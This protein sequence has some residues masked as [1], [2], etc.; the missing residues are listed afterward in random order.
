MKPHVQSSLSRL[1]KWLQVWAL[2]DLLLFVGLGNGVLEAQEW[3]TYTTIDGLANND[4][5]SVYQSRDGAMW[6]GTRGGVSRFDGTWQTFTIAEGL[7]NNVVWSVFESRDGAMWFG[8]E[9]GGVSRYD[10]KNWQTFTAEDGL[11]D[12]NIWAVF[13]ARDGAMWFGARDYETQGGGGG[14]SRYDGEN[15][16]S[17]T[18]ADGLL[19]N[20]VWSIFEARDGA[21][22]FGTVHVQGAEGGGVSRY[23]GESWQ[24]Y[25]TK[26]GLAENNVRS[27]FQSRD[28]AMWFG[29]G[30]PVAIGSNAGGVSRYDGESWQTFT[31]ADGLS[32]NNVWSVFEDRDGTMWFGTR[33]FSG[34]GSSAGVS[35][36]DGKNWQVLTTEDGLADNFVKDIFQS[37]DGAMWFATTV[38]ISRYDET[39]RTFTTSDGLANNEIK[40]AFQSRDGTMWFGSLDVLGGAGGLNRYDGKNW[41]VF[42]TTDGLANNNVWSIF[43]SH[44]NA[45]WFGSVD[46]LGGAGGGVSR[47]DGEHWQTFTTKDGLANNNV[48]SIFQ[49]QAGAMWFG[50]GTSSL[51]G[52]SGGGGV[53]RYDGEHWQTFTTKD[54]LIHDIVWSIYQSR[55]SAMWFG[56]GDVFQSSGGGVN[57]YDGETWQSFTTANGLASNQVG[58][59]LQTEDDAMWFGTIGGVTR[60]KG[61]EWQTYTE[62]DGLAGNVVSTMFQNQ[63]GTMWFGTNGGVSVF[64]RPQE[65]LVE[66]VILSDFPPILGINRFFIESQGYEIGSNRL[67][68]LSFALVSGTGLPEASDWSAFAFVDR[69]AL[70]EADLTNGQ[71]RFFV[72]AKDRFGNIDPTPDS[73][74][75]TLD[76]T[77]PAV[78]ISNPRR[79]DAVSGQVWIEGSVF[80]GSTIPDLKRFTLSYGKLGENGE[81]LT[82]N[83]ISEAEID[84]RGFR[85]EDA[86]IASWDTEALPEPFGDY[87]LRLWAE[88]NLGHTNEHQIPITIVSAL[89]TLKSQDG[90]TVEASAGTVSLKIPPNGLAADTQVQIGFTDPNEIPA[91]PAKVRTTGIAYRIGPDN[92]I[93]KKRSTLTIGYNPANL[94]GF[95]EANL[96]IFALKNTWIRLGGTVDKVANEITVGIHSTGT[97]AMF[98]SPVEEGVP[99]VSEIACQPRIIS[100]A[101]GIYP[102]TTDITFHLGASARV[103]VCIYS[104]SGNLVRVVEW[105]RTLNAGWNTVQWNGRNR[106]DQFVRSGIYIVAIDA[107]GK[108]ANKT[109]AVLGR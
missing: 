93:F 14:V 17:F 107:E 58:I 95:D 79:N 72:R 86:A 38:G 84:V 12:N 67:P 61:T 4:V 6:F 101:G 82:W 105:E 78:T 36:Y 7:T 89:E 99:S 30:G 44:D 48:W 56:S 63:N 88:D 50:V 100:P 97:Y 98:E 51:S 73:I 35:R 104:V 16:Q 42:T 33:N 22:W 108:T 85:I 41:Q 83:Q 76:L 46:V 3:Y 90:G 106:T 31:A 34:S 5:L 45:M 94:P 24:S 109:V 49:S 43:Q 9:G 102:A 54:G 8:T 70:T 13:E 62:A 10:G 69:F 65:A 80:D 81:V 77:G 75:F 68:P 15:W 47:Y 1:R 103:N 23:D 19:G 60:L 29:T 57:R 40:S 39:W 28:G 52:G 87:M 21:M 2:L 27:I 37:R 66:T 74:T 64:K 32:G 53:S 92:L 25:T 96:S 59:I 91:P 18:A 55:D 26:D 11:V 71:W 20:N